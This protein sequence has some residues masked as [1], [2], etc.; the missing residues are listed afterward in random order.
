MKWTFSLRDRPNGMKG[1]TIIWS[2]QMIAGI[3]SGITAVALPVWVFQTTGSGIQVGLLEFFFFGSYLLFVQVAGV[4]VDRYHRKMLMLAHDFISLSSIAV[5]LAIESTGKLM[6]WH[7]FVAAIFQGIGFAFYSPSFSAAITTMLPR[8]YYVRANGLMSLLDSVPEIF[9]PLLAGTLILAIGL[10]GVL[11]INLLAFVVSIG[12]L[13]FVEVPPTPQ[14]PEGKGSHGTFFKEAIYGLR[15]IIHRRGLLGLQMIFF[16]GNLF[17]GIALSA[18]AL[19]PM[20]LLRTGNDTQAIGAVQSVGALI[21]VIAAII[22]ASRKGMKQ[23]VR[24][25]LLG[26]ILSSLLGLTLLGVGQFLLIWLL[27]ISLNSLFEPLIN[28][29]LETFL[30]TKVPPD[31]QGRVFSATDFLTQAMIPFTPLLAGYFGDRVLEP[32]FRSQ[33]A[34]SN[35]FGWLVGTGPGSGF[36]LLLVICGLCSALTGVCGFL[37]PSIR[38]LERSIPDYAPPVAD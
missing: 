11:A 24:V 10:N 21:A 1:F 36:G 37:F 19:Y 2:G 30:Q 8:Y 22:L 38:N 31:L 27:A 7:L 13:L 32:I 29:A 16:F 6:P 5:L 14:T 26:W 20:I 4:M 28:V 25:I 35:L 17:S 33:N 15:Y 9:G 23:L 3:A 12:A 18:A 34:L